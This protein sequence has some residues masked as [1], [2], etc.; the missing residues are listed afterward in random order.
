M[1]PIKEILTKEIKAVYDAAGQPRPYHIS[2]ATNLPSGTVN[3]ALNCE[4]TVKN[5]CIVYDHL[6]KLSKK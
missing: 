2:K 5:W 1:T 6:N 4:G 3:A